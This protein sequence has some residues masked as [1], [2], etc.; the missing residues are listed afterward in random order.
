MLDILICTDNNMFSL[1]IE[2]QDIRNIMRLL[3]INLSYRGSLGMCPDIKG[4]VLNDHMDKARHIIIQLDGH[5]H[6][7]KKMPHNKKEF[8]C[9]YPST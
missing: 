6:I 3:H 2:F 4:N 5:S 8:R 1:L 9:R 7:K